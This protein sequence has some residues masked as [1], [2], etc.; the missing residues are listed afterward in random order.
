MARRATSVAECEIGALVP[1]RPADHQRCV[2]AALSMHGAVV[3]RPDSA[4]SARWIAVRQALL[5]VGSA[6]SCR[7]DRLI[8]SAASARPFRCM[9]LSSRDRIRQHLLGGSQC[10]KRCGVW[11]RRA[12]AVSTGRSSAIRRRPLQHI[13]LSSHELIQTCC[14]VPA[15]P[16]FASADARLVAGRHRHPYWCAAFPGVR[17]GRLTRKCVRD[18]IQIPKTRS[19]R[20]TGSGWKT[21][22]SWHLLCAARPTV[23]IW[24]E[25]YYGL[26]SV[27]VPEFECCDRA[28]DLRY[29][30]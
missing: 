10:D 23:R 30:E 28:R 25:V 2:G 16:G 22:R 19:G 11:V 17:V 8:I 14:A 13:V 7:F 15:A 20:S 3:A 4:A 18:Y 29:I 12:R 27:E 6:R 9:A 1:F 26:P 21:G 24:A 5:G